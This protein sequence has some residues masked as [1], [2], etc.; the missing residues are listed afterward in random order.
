MNYPKRLSSCLSLFLLVSLVWI[1]DGKTAW[2]EPGIEYQQAVTKILKRGDISW[3]NKADNYYKFSNIVMASADGS[4]VLFTGKCEFCDKAEVRPFL[5]NPDG[6]GLKDISDML[7]SDITSRWFGW[8]NMTIC[9][10]GSKVFFRAVV[11]TGYYDDEYLYVYDVAS[12]ITRLAI[13]MDD[14]FSPFGSNWRFRI[15]ETGT[16]VYMDKY[17]AGWDETLQ[18]HKKGLF[19]ADTGS[20]RQWYFDIDELSCQS[21]CGN[22]NMFNLMGVSVQNDRAFFQWNSDYNKTDGS[23]Q[24]IRLYYTDL[25]GNHIALSDEHYLIYDGDWR[26]ISDT[27][28]DTVIY[29]YIHE[30]G[31]P[32]KL[33][34]VDVASKTLKDVAWTKGL[35]GFKAH[36]SRSGEYVLVNGE[37]G[38]GGTYYQT[39]LDL[40]SGT[41]RDTWSY[42]M[43]S[44]WGGTSNITKDDRYYFY[45]IDE[46]DANSGLYRIDTRTTGDDNAP[47]INSIKFS[48]PA[49]LDQEDTK[50]SVQVEISDPQG[51]NNIEWVTLLPLIDG[52]E[53]PSWPMGRAPLAFPSGDPGSIRL[54]DDGTHG[55]SAAGDGIY[56]FDSIS[57]RKDG[58]DGDGWN[59]WYQ[60]YTLPADLGI[61]V[62]VKDKENN[63]TIADTT[64][65]ITDD[66]KDISDSQDG[67]C[68]TITEDLYLEIP[69]ATYTSPS[70]SF[71][72]WLDFEYAGINSDGY[73]IWRLGKFGETEQGSESECSNIAGDLGLSVPCATLGNMIF[74]LRFGYAGQDINNYPIWRLEDIG[75]VQ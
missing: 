47:Y 9:D 5:V 48:A 32:R 23:N 36:M 57:T 68:S 1:T 26:G 65:R 51:I 75:N 49:L 3:G 2:Y 7:P 15:N 12:G 41:S 33:A 43:M 61:R 70:G 16:R 46:N 30:Y 66:P 21:Q 67:T 60:H 35:N 24:H 55:D 37:Y 28:G 63:Y 22:M 56:T 13:E 53:D 54:Y 69:C 73:N 18:K 50:I 42:Y 58:R 40:E 34:V 31:T 71:S 59:T 14:G 29:C 10:D 17:D 27:K 74:R 6:S 52:Q 64:L 72:M 4:K 62:I 8:N 45:T 44:R 11:E 39:M 38:D 19:Y 20:T 25:S